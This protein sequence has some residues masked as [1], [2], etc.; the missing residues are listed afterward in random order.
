M[1]GMSR[2]QSLKRIGTHRAAAQTGKQRIAGCAPLLLHPLL[3]DRD[4]VRPQ[5]RATLFAALA[6]TADMGARTQF[7]VLVAQ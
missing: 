4:H 6:Q 3:E 2:H 5:R 1:G 7:H